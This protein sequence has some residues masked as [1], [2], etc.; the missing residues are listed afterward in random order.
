MNNWTNLHQQGDKRLL[1]PC[2]KQANQQMNIK[3]HVAG[4]PQ[5]FPVLEG[6][7]DCQGFGQLSKCNHRRL[8]QNARRQGNHRRW[9]VDAVN[10]S[11]TVR[12]S[13][14]TALNHLQWK[15]G[16]LLAQQ[17]MTLPRKPW[18]LRLNSS[19]FNSFEIQQ[20]TGVKLNAW[21][22]KILEKIW[23]QLIFEKIRLAIEV[24]EQLR[25]FDLTPILSKNLIDIVNG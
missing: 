9:Q 21:A 20:R 23:Y 12:F 3:D 14:C 4:K 13:F 19:S 7:W 2:P 8:L 6:F 25:C 15:L 24:K 16:D 5:F 10:Q 22:F 18:K 11:F 17:L 1:C